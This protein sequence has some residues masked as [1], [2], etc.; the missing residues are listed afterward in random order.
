MLFSVLSG[1]I[2]IE[3]YFNFK[4]GLILGKTLKSISLYTFPVKMWKK[5][6]GGILHVNLP[7]GIQPL[8]DIDNTSLL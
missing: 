1:N 5:G 2:Y 6:K 4:K 8:T 3:R 7:P